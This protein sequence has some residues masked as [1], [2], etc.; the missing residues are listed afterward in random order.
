MIA[1]TPHM[2]TVSKKSRV[3]PSEAAFVTTRK[4]ARKPPKEV[5]TETQP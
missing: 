3:N 2:P 1:V 4:H 5:V